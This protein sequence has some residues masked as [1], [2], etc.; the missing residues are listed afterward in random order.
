MR[1]DETRQ[2]DDTGGESQLSL[3]DL[4]AM[5]RRRFRLIATVT[6]LASLAAISMV[7][8]WPNRYEA[9][10]VI[11]L[12]PRP[13]TV[14]KFENVYED[15]KA[16]TPTI[17]S[18]AEIA[19]SGP[20]LRDVM[21]RLDLMNDP[22]LTAEAGALDEVWRRF[23]V[24][25]PTAALPPARPLPQPVAAPRPSDFEQLSGARG[26]TAGLEREP[27]LAALNN[28]VSAR[29][30]R[31]TQLIEIRYSSRDPVKAARIATAIAESYILAQINAKREGAE[32][33][34]AQIEKRILELK[35][36]LAEHERAI[37]TLRT[38]LG[39]YQA[40]GGQLSE[41]QLSRQMEGVIEARRRTADAAARY[42]EARR[43]LATG[44]GTVAPQ[45]AAV[46]EMFR[47]NSLRTLAEA[48]EK[49]ERRR[50][51]LRQKYG[52]LHPERQRGEADAEAARSGLA[53]ELANIVATA[54]SE[55]A[56]SE[57]S[58]RQLD[59]RDRKS[60]V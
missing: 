28:R 22:E 39:L 58:E 53:A 37:E 16:D 1:R 25:V 38:E 27:A 41:R 13:K 5:L 18:E 4:G 11:Q 57:E 32:V 54:R 14:T 43:A 55:L 6:L 34:N 46:P 26:P 42:E 8:V 21:M 9:I 7:L 24:A 51:D 2:Q 50:D 40:D 10:A 59:Q 48:L 31:N 35:G 15:L 19:I 29:R 30:L 45:T 36:G 47:S 60:V 12:D 17:E 44:P 49:A 3:G 56:I 20:V 52:P 33:A 23:G